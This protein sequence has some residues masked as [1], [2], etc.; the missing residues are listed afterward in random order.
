MKSRGHAGLE[1][2]R[3]E[4]AVLRRGAGPA[5]RSAGRSACRPRRR[6]GPARRRSAP[7]PARRPGTGSGRGDRRAS[8]ASSSGCGRRTRT[9][10][11]RGRSPRGRRTGGDGAPPRRPRSTGP[12][13]A[14]STPG[15]AGAGRSTPVGWTTRIAADC[16]H[17][18]GSAVQGA[19]EDREHEHEERDAERRRR[20]DVEQLEPFQEVDQPH[21]EHRL[22]DRPEPVHLGRVVRRRAEG[23]AGQLADRHAEHRQHRDR[24]DLDDG[25]VDRR[26][27][28]P[29]AHPGARCEARSGLALRSPGFACVPGRPL[30][31]QARQGTAPVTPRPARLPRPPPFARRRAHARSR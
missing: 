16:C 1:A 12:G 27:Q 2:G 25:E 30:D 13:P 23:E 28:A 11:R 9:A 3:L 10:S 19:D 31:R 17:S 5:C 22:V 26:E 24:D 15:R 20:E 18:R 14:R 4:R 6:R 29:Q 8:P 7:S 21:A